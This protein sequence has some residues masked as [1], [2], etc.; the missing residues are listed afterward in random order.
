MYEL[1]VTTDQ[2]LPHINA[3]ENLSLEE[4]PSLPAVNLV[5]YE[6]AGN[7]FGTVGNFHGES[8]NSTFVD[9]GLQDR[10]LFGV[11]GGNLSHVDK[12]LLADAKDYLSSQNAKDRP[13]PLARDI[14]EWKLM[15]PKSKVG[16]GRR[17]GAK[18]AQLLT[19]TASSSGD[20]ETQEGPPAFGVATEVG[21]HN[22]KSIFG[23]YQ[24][25]A[26]MIPKE[27]VKETLEKG[28]LQTGLI[29]DY[30]AVKKKNL[31]GSRKLKQVF[32]L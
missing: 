8:V 26:R 6:D 23:K 30:Y 4:G 14:L 11:Q 7:S 1:V 16:D 15:G 25:E 10:I 20:V 3:G 13:R 18:R 2:S 32:D 27:L 12:N 31:D 9:S 24:A 5:D 29:N 28:N 22:Q 17:V 19:G 21:K